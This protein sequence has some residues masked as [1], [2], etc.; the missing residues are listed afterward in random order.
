MQLSPSFLRGRGKAPSADSWATRPVLS[1]SIRAAV[2]LAPAT[3]AIVVSVAVSHVVS[4]PSSLGM[5]LLW[6]L[7]L[8]ALSTALL[9]VA[10]RQLRRLL[11]LAALLRLSLVFPDK[12]PS[13]FGAAMRMGSTRRLEE[14]LTQARKAEAGESVNEAAVRLVELATALTTHDRRT[15]GHSERVRAYAALLG[16]E[17]HLSAADR[18]ALQWAALLHDIGKLFVPA[19]ILNKRGAPTPEEWD[20]IR[21]HPAHAR[22]L[23]APVAEWLGPFAAAA[24]EHH[25]RWDGT[26]YPA[27]IAGAEISL[28]GRIVAVA[29]AYEVITAA[30]SYKKPLPAAEARAELTR[31]AGAHFDPT[32]VRALL[33]VSTGRLRKVMGPVTWIAQLPFLGWSAP[34]A[35][36][37]TTAA[38]ARTV[39]IAATV[40]A[41]APALAPA[42]HRSTPLPA[43]AAVVALAAS[44]APTTTAPSRSTAPAASRGGASQPGSPTSLAPVAG[45][46]PATTSVPAPS[47]QAS[48]GGTVPQAPVAGAAPQPGAAPSPTTAVAVTATTVR[49]VAPAP[50]PPAPTSPT[51]TPPAPTPPVPAPA[52]PTTT[53]APR[54]AAPTTTAAPA[55]IPA[56]LAACGTS[57]VGCNLSGANLAGL[58]LHGRN[59]SGANLKSANLAGADLAGAIAIGANMMGATLTAANLA[60]AQLVGTNLQSAS[61]SGAN[62]T[63]A[64]LTGDNM[65][66]D[67]LTGAA[68]T[69]AVLRSTNDKSQ[70]TSASTV[71]SNTTCSDGTNSNS[72]QGSCLNH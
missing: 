65:R 1:L 33:T 56:V 11:P 17:L 67:D 58:D 12:A 10:D 37:L 50:A 40:T 28:A 7:G 22:E 19:E 9:V 16:E 5:R 32:V 6:L 51:T 64:N 36:P 24:W 27:G 57:L 3:L 23:L 2:L 31:C 44:S 39:L 47:P 26:G 30:R 15:R 69:N 53:V 29:D 45:G 20:I 59:L 48:V 68:L 66:A 13:R 25:E 55:P 70:A 8:G 43:P 18:N 60:G 49:P 61:L 54:P 72:D 41:V 34:A 42:P 35:L 62:L 14:R 63:G 46:A 4:A 52:A 38:I 21:A 71:W